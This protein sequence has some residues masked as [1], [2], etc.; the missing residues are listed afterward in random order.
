M[1]LVENL[2]IWL[3]AFLVL[4]LFSFLYKD[5]PFYKL[6]EHVFAGLSAGYY[7]GLV[8][9]AVIIQ[10]LVNPMF[11]DGRWW[12]LFP[13]MLGVLMFARFFAKWSWISRASLA[14]V[15]GN[16]A[17]VFLIS[18]LH[19]LILPQVRST[20][21]SLD[22]RQGFAGTLLALVIVIGVISTL[23]Y[24][25]FSKEHKGALGVTAQVGI[26]FIMISFG[27]HFGYTVMA[28]ISLLIGQ[29]QFLM[30]DWLGSIRQLF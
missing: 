28:R 23:I 26:W 29:V 13:A 24:F 14:F 18:Q 10:Q 8:W 25:Y 3:G 12:L 27:A 15:M 11:D 9:Q 7:V 2:Q 21:L 1:S 22:P 17:G 19:G 6:A 30:F 4:S 5:N 20:M 16:T